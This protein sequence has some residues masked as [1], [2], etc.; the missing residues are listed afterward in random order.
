MTGRMSA[1]ARNRRAGIDR[2]TAA[3]QRTGDRHTGHGRRRPRHTGRRATL[4]GLLALALALALSTSALALAPPG[5][6]TGGASSVGYGSAT[7]LGAIDPHGSATSYYFQYGPTAAYGSQT[8]LAQVGAGTGT[9]KVSAAISGLQALTVYHYRLVA[10]N[11]GGAATGVGRA[12]TTTKIPL[13]LQIV[14][15]PNPVLYGAPVVIQGTLSGT[16]NG[17]RT[18]VLQANPFPYTQGFADI[19]N[20]ATTFA[21]GGFSFALVS[22]NTATQFRVLTTTVP[23]VAS[24]IAQENVAVRVSA[25][26]A[27]THRRHYARVYGTVTPA[28]NGMEV[29]IMR[30]VGGR[31]V[32]VSGTV[33]RQLNATSSR[34]SRTIRV[35]Q[36]ALYRVLVR[37]TNGA[38]VSN[39]SAPLFIR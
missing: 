19:G 6:Y 22:L 35:H 9:V 34:F 16:G 20:P 31:N 12:F 15:A 13:S 24:P 39:Y 3:T 30:V 26:V 33:L 11:A 5:V 2:R 10:V 1:Q 17:G 8:P 27:A 14:A 25:H 37:V 23:P 36:H 32:L 29:G 7:L 21:D 18:V 28:V 38:Q 4:A